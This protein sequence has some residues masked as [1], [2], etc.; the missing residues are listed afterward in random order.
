MSYCIDQSTRTI[1]L[2]C[3]RGACR[4]PIYLRVIDRIEIVASDHA[5]LKSATRQHKIPH[6]LDARA[7]PSSK[8]EHTMCCE[9]APGKT[10]GSNRVVTIGR[11]ESNTM[12]SS[13]EE[14]R[15]EQLN[16]RSIGCAD[17]HFLRLL[18]QYRCT[19]PMQHVPGIANCGGVASL[20][21][22]KPAW[23]ACFG[24]C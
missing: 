17:T 19:P 14:T 2:W 8:G 20:Q 12:R 15:I 18:L 22:S 4:V 13:P 1:R 10:I 9:I 5:M 6:R 21:A 11:S 24:G 16:V 3:H 7:D 23:C